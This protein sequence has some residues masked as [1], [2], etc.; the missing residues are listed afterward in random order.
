MAVTMKDIAELAG[1]SQQAVSAALNGNGHSRVSAATR[2]RVLKLA[3]ELNYVPNAAAAALSGKDSKTI[4]IMA[5]GLDGLNGCLIEELSWLF[6]RSGCNTVTTFFDANIVDAN[7]AFM[8]LVSRGARGVV[9]LGTVSRTK[10]QNFFTVPAVF[11]FSSFSD[12]GSDVFTDFEK[13]AELIIEHLVDQHGHKRLAFVAPQASGSILKYKYLEKAMLKRGIEPEPEWVIFLRD[14]GGSAKKLFAHLEEQRISALFSSN[15]YVG[16]KII[17]AALQY[18]VRVPQDLAVVGYD[19]YSFTEF[20]AVSLTTVVQPIRLRAKKIV[21]LLE[22]RIVDNELKP[23]TA[24]IKLE[25]ELHIGGSC[26]CEEPL[27]NNLY[28]LNTFSL[29]ERDARMNFSSTK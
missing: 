12:D 8:E 2:D 21:E 7:N 6:A 18:G 23:P 26:G 10:L 20:S 5:A 28:Q 1:I 13:S 11:S 4:G 3:E 16:S 14:I 22:Q 19:G 24:N 29:L 17:K 25:P 27:I 9:V 15:D